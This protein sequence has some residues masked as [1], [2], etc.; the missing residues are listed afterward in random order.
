MKYKHL[1][2]FILLF[3]KAIMAQAAFPAIADT[4]SNKPIAL[5]STRDYIPPPPPSGRLID[6][7]TNI[8]GM[9]ALCCAIAAPVL[10]AFMSV[11]SVLAATIC[12]IIALSTG[13]R[14]P[15]NKLAL[16]AF[17]VA[18]IEMAILMFGLCLYLLVSL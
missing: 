12:F 8:W 3:A 13:N 5:H 7:E 11:Y 15:E 17:R 9:L 10:L 2:I 18:I 4:F 6:E 16:I 1:F 14:N